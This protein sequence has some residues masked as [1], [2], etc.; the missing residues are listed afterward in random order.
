MRGDGRGKI[1]SAY[2]TF[3]FANVEYADMTLRKV[4][5]ND[6]DEYERQERIPEPKPMVLWQHSL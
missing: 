3:G 1:V 5:S 6:K 4:C 2:S